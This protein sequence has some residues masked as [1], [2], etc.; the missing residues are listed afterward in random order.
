METH[1]HLAT[2][3]SLYEGDRKLFFERLDPAYVCHTPGA[4]AIAG[5]F[6]GPDGMRRHG[7]MMRDL[8]DGTF[9]ARLRGAIVLDDV[10]ALAP[11]EISARRKGRELRMPAFGI[12]RF[13]GERVMEHWENPLDM[14]AFDAFWADIV[15]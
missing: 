11:V 3:L 12:W 5:H 15:E 14:F 2:L 8:T 10:H 6:V 7:Q 13:E 1:T 9:R 4:S